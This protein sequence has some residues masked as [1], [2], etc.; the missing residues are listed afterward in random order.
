MPGSTKKTGDAA[1]AAASG[2][3]EPEKKE[4]KK[5]RSDWLK[6]GECKV[7]VEDIW[8]GN[9]MNESNPREVYDMHGGIYIMVSSPSP[10]FGR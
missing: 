7:M 4:E 3:K 10:S 6:S 8:S 9:V 2:D 1:A 5:W